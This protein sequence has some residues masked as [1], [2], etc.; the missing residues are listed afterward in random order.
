MSW[1]RA[2]SADRSSV[3]SRGRLRWRP[4]PKVA[5]KGCVVSRCIRAAL[6]DPDL[7]FSGSSS[8]DMGSFFSRSSTVYASFTCASWSETRESCQP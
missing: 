5:S 3:A 6:P 7:G 8:S 1:L 2:S 4:L